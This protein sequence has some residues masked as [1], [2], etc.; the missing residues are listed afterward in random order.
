MLRLFSCFRQKNGYIAI[1]RLLFDD[2]KMAYKP[3]FNVP[4]HVLVRNKRMSPRPCYFKTSGM[5]RV[6]LHRAFV[7][8]IRKKGRLIA[9]LF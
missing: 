1:L 6:A 7:Y 3:T 2:S 9:K 5:I 8:K 4:T